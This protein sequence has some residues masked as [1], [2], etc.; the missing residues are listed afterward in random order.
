MIE[1]AKELAGLVKS[2]GNMELYQ[3]VLEL[4]TEML[5]LLNQKAQAE[6]RS[7][8]LEREVDGLKQQQI[9]AKELN[10]EKNCYW[11][12]TDAEPRSPYCSRCWD[13]LKDL[14]RMLHHVNGVAVC[15]SCKTQAIAWPE[16]ASPHLSGD[17]ATRRSG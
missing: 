13:V 6:R 8:E 4:Q 3:K 2:L 9:I 10:F 1:T 5:E 12:T 16:K 17:E 14:V 11:R 7:R 15:A